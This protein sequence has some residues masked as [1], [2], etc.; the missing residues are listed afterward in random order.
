MY[1]GLAISLLAACRALIKRVY[2]FSN[3][4]HMK[5]QAK[6]VTYLLTYLLVGFFTLNVSPVSAQIPCPTAVAPTNIPWTDKG[7]YQLTIVPGCVVEVCYCTRTVNGVNQ[8]TIKS[9]RFL[10]KTSCPDMTWQDAIEW[11]SDI[12]AHG[13]TND[14]ISPCLPGYEPTVYEIVA[15]SCWQVININAHSIEPPIWVCRPCP[16]DVGYCSILKKICDHGDGNYTITEVS[17][18]FVPGNCTVEAPYLWE[19]NTCYVFN[20]CDQ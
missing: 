7:C 1:R 20:L 19:P 8:Y 5:K 3:L 6:S 15:S 10:N 2:H 9:L 13:L 12:L 11:A 14:A 4:T 18:T 17:R 16:E